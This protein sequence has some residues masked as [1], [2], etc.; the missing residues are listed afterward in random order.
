MVKKKIIHKPLALVFLKNSGW[1]LKLE[2]NIVF[3][4]N[5]LLNLENPVKTF[6][7]EKN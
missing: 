4:K 5:F 6:Y 1:K 2:K 3:P 7:W